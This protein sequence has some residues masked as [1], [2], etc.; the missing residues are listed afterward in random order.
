MW[1][2]G[3][4]LSRRQ[5]V[6]QCHDEQ[7]GKEHI[8]A[9]IEHEQ[10]RGVKLSTVRT[11]LHSSGES[12]TIWGS[13]LYGTLLLSLPCVMGTVHRSSPRARLRRI[14]PRQPRLDAPDTLHQV[15][16]RGIVRTPPF[17]DT[18]DRADCFACLASLA[19]AGAFTVYACN[20][21]PCIL[22]LLAS[23]PHY[24]LPVTSRVCREPGDNIL[25]DAVVPEADATRD[26]P[27]PLGVQA[28]GASGHGWR[29]GGA[30]ASQPVTYI[31]AGPLFHRQRITRILRRQRRLS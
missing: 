21:G 7:P 31:A 25:P 29:G 22:R 17:R 12:W 24:R 13:P 5:D 20:G 9:S 26:P 14:M 11:K 2:C 27:D 15:L 30:T 8:G 19:E 16:G 1:C 28:Q 4:Y 3:K 10:D 6:K 18:G 23:I